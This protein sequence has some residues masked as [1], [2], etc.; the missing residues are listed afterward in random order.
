M[1]G[2][3]GREG[4]RHCRVGRL[5]FPRFR[6]VSFRSVRPG[7]GFHC[8][9]RRLYMTLEKLSATSWML[10]QRYKRSTTGRE[11]FASRLIS[12]RER[13]ECWAS[14]G[15]EKA[16]Q[17]LAHCLAPGPPPG[18]QVSTAVPEQGQPSFLA[19]P[20]AGCMGSREIASPS[21]APGLSQPIGFSFN[22]INGWKCALMFSYY[23]YLCIS[24]CN[25]VFYRRL[26][27]WEQQQNVCFLQICG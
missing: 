20:G 23:A 15:K 24:L 2:G 26:K 14:G 13:E 11:S 4:W 8:L 18:S 17:R 21:R 6:S 25:M 12:G 19:R 3:R 16:A 1:S 7:G 10:W 22:P 5:L 9:N 27:T